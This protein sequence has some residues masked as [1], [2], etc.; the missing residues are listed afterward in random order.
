MS[1][2]DK[3]AHLLDEVIGY[4]GVREPVKAMLERAY[5]KLRTQSKEWTRRRVRSIFNKEAKRIDNFE[6]EQMRAVISAR[7]AHAKYKDETSRIASMGVI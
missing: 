3:A 4:R 1:D 6:M 2:V 7:N 5:S